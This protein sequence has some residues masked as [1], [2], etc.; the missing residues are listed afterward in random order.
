M[1]INRYRT[2]SQWYEIML[3]FYDPT[4][5]GRGGGSVNTEQTNVGQLDYIVTSANCIY[6]LICFYVFYNNV[7]ITF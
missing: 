3:P 5:R 6:T 7:S 4:G 2:Y 1:A